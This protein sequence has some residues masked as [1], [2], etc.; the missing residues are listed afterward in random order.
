MNALSQSESSNTI[1]F[2]EQFR[3]EFIHTLSENFVTKHGKLGAGSGASVLAMLT[4][5]GVAN[6]HATIVKKILG[7]TV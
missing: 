2:F 4:A 1:A 7:A 6:F 3:N 5:F